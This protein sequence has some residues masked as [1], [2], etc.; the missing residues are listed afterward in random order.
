MEKNSGVFYLIQDFRNLKLKIGLDPNEGS[1]E[2]ANELDDA[3]LET[4]YDPSIVFVLDIKASKTA[5][6]GKANSYGETIPLKLKKE[7]LPLSKVDSW[8]RKLHDYWTDAPFSLDDLRWASVEHYYQ[9]AKFKKQ[10]PDFYRLFSLDSPGSKFNDNITKARQAGSKDANKLR[11]K[12]IN[13]DPDF[14]GERNKEER[15]RALEAKFQQNSDLKEILKLTRT[16][17]LMGFIRHSTS[18]I[19]IDL[20]NLRKTFLS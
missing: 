16:A 12:N 3:Y 19:D 14:Y 15:K 17:K 9:A 10:N 18:E 6:P 7:Y 4:L 1:P 13:M 2:E 8:R 5:Y 11:P 20:M